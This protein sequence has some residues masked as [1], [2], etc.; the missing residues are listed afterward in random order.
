ML[1]AR[2]IT[3]KRKNRATII[4]AGRFVI[5]VALIIISTNYFFILT[6]DIVTERGEFQENERAGRWSINQSRGAKRSRRKSGEN[7]RG[8]NEDLK[9]RFTFHVFRGSDVQTAGEIAPRVATPRKN[10]VLIPRSY[11][12]I[13]RARARVPVFLPRLIDRSM[14]RRP[15]AIPIHRPIADLSIPHLPRNLMKPSAKV[16]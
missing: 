1:P 12:F 16:E 4:N 9:V 5:C 11:R 2:K 14:P 6:W 15:L 3:T 10:S 13:S 8:F 7:R